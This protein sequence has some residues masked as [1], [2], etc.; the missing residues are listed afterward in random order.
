MLFNKNLKY[1]QKHE[2]I[3]NVLQN[4]PENQ[5]R[6]F[7]PSL[8]VNQFPR[9]SLLRYTTPL[10]IQGGF[11]SKNKKQVHQLINHNKKNDDRVQRQYGFDDSDDLH[12]TYSQLFDSFNALQY[13]VK[14]TFVSY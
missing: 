11:I 8:N 7:V 14:F 3:F 1:R 13:T 10:R 5:R 2:A 9:S 4:L 12:E 6:L